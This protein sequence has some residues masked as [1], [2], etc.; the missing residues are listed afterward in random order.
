MRLVYRANGNEW[1][2]S[3]H[4]LSLA[5]FNGKPECV[6][7]FLASKFSFSLILSFFSIH[8]H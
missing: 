4:V 7:F 2:T 8:F 5:W 3:F 1:E 6:K